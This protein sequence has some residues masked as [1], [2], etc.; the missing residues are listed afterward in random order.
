MIVP[1]Y[2]FIRNDRQALNAKGL[3]KTGGGLMVYLSN[4][5]TY[6]RYKRGGAS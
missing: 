4:D 2:Q 3:I 1:G 6:S 5:V